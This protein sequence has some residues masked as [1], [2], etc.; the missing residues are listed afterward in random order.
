MGT[1]NAHKEVSTTNKIK[2]IQGSIF[3]EKKFT[4]CK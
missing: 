2:N 3:I 1:Q 4:N